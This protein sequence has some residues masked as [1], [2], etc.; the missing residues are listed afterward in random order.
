[1]IRKKQSNKRRSG[2]EGPDFYQMPTSGEDPRTKQQNGKGD[3]ANLDVL[4]SLRSGAIA[5][6]LGS[7]SAGL[8]QLNYAQQHQNQMLIANGIP[9]AGGGFSA[10]SAMNRGIVN[11][12]IGT[13]SNLQVDVFPMN[14][15]SS[16]AL[17][18]FP[19]GR[20]SLPV[21]NLNMN[22]VGHQSLLGQSNGCQGSAFNSNSN[23]IQRILLR[24]ALYGVNANTSMLQSQQLMGGVGGNVGVFM[25]SSVPGNGIANQSI[26]DD[27]NSLQLEYN[28][29]AMRAIQDNQQSLNGSLPLASLLS[30]QR[31]AQQNVSMQGMQNDSMYN[32]HNNNGDNDQDGLMDVRKKSDDITNEN[33][34]TTSYPQTE[35]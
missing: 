21:R 22:L 10:L 16:S 25:N 35:R 8:R 19:I 9:N 3:A 27:L 4:G 29:A 23:E 30:F 31:Q 7:M 18:G 6:Q 20:Q 32:I 13:G 1:M 15:S 34:C 12:S 26:P 5:T 11:N 17:S 33:K 24:Q 28:L 2:G 14:E